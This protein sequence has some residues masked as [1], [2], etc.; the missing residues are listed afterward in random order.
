MAYMESVM[1]FRGMNF[2]MVLAA[3]RIA[4]TSLTW[5]DWWVPSILR[6]VFAKWSDSN[7]IPLPQRAFNFP[8]LKQAPL[9]NTVTSHAHS[10]T[11]GV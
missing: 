8:L 5:L 11:R 2:S 4:T 1:I 7:H 10:V 3:F 6:A 9:V